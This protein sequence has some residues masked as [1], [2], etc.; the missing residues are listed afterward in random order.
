MNKKIFLIPIIFM[1]FLTACSSSAKGYKRKK[2]KK[3]CDCPSW[4][5]IKDTSHFSKHNK[6]AIA[7]S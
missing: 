6:V 5:S 2:T 7:Y 1:L 3:N 4:S